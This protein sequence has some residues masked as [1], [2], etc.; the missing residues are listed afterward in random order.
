VKTFRKLRI[1]LSENGLRWTFY[2][3]L[4][5]LAPGLS[6]LLDRRMKT[7]ETRYGLPGDKSVARNYFEWQTHDWK[8]GG[9][10]WSPSLEWK[11]SLIDHVLLKYIEPGKSVLEIGPGAG[12]WTETLQKI[13]ARLIVVD[14]SDV[15]IEQC[16]R[17]FTGCANI[18]YFVNNGTSL[19]FLPAAS[20]DRV[21]SFDVFVHIR[22]EDTERYLAE[23]SRVLRAGSRGVI[24]RPKVE[25]GHGGWRSR[26]T[27]E[28]FV[29]MLSRNGFNLVAQFDSWGPG[30]RFDVRAHQD[31][32]TV[33]EKQ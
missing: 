11:Q 29:A 3:L 5:R 21:W 22:P 32:I 31:M 14:L 30:G 13:S 28:L 8:A 18:E 6:K 15:C 20:I 23:L 17:R 9:E 19:E 25:Q 12:R 24:H 27:S 4:R 7:L 26:T 2:L 10:E 1:L 33:F 16:R